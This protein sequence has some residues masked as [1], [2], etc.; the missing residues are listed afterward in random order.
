MAEL[1]PINIIFPTA[2]VYVDLKGHADEAVRNAFARLTIASIS[3]V[4]SAIKKDIILVQ[5]SMWGLGKNG[6]GGAGL[7]QAGG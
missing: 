3:A 2:M 7:G 6:E 1:S 4:C 5:I